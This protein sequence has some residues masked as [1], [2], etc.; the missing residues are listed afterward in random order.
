MHRA[1][2]SSSSSSSSS[3]CFSIV[4][5][6]LISSLAISDGY[7]KIVSLGPTRYNTPMHNA[8]LVVRCG[9]T[10]NAP[11]RTEQYYADNYQ[12]RRINDKEAGQLP[13]GTSKTNLY[14]FVVQCQAGA[15]FRG[16]ER[17]RC[18]LCVDPLMYEI[19]T[20]IRFA[21]NAVVSCADTAKKMDDCHKDRLTEWELYTGHL[22]TTN[23]RHWRFVAPYCPRHIS[24]TITPG[25][26]PTTTTTSAATTTT[27]T[28]TMTATTT[29]DEQ[30]YAESFVRTTTTADN[31]TDDDGYDDYEEKSQKLMI[32]K[33][34]ESNNTSAAAAADATEDE[35][36]G[37]GTKPSLTLSLLLCFLFLSGAIIMFVI[38]FTY[39]GGMWYG[40]DWNRLKSEV[41][42]RRRHRR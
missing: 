38:W 17:P 13:A 21:D 8:P 12:L 30:F 39:R 28:T 40:C 15:R 33:D 22:F 1:H 10:W 2:C 35:K 11:F 5:L 31:A 20:L 36:S 34:V 26:V 16:D 32:F 4:L 6:L 27:T 9:K 23:G 24:I 25:G 3:S 37:G 14:A 18:P 29:I 42:R 7:G 19:V 41:D